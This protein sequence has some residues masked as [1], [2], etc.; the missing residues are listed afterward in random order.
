MQ[1]NTIDVPFM[2]IIKKIIEKLSVFYANH[3][4]TYNAIL[5]F[6]KAFSNKKGRSQFF[7]F[8]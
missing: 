1:T 3:F 4:N 8:P 7:N 5:L 2:N 6:I